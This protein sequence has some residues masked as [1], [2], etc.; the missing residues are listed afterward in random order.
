MSLALHLAWAYQSAGKFTDARK[1]FQRAEE[2]GLRPE[3]RD[4]LERVVI[5]DLR[6][7]LLANPTST[8]SSG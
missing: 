7:V 2:L 3:V 8:S 5:D 1:A 4:P 6:K